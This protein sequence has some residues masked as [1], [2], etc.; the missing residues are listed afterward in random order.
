M[1][2]L[3]QLLLPPGINFVFI[4]IGCLIFVRWRKTGAAIIII[5][6]ILLYLLSTPYIANTLIQHLERFHILK[7]KHL[8]EIADRPAICNQEN[9]SI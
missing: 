9:E 1:A 7:F 5:S 2:P 4:L 6:I 8:V 3:K